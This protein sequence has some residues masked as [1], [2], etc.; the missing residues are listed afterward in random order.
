MP[1][2]FLS[3][4]AP[5]ASRKRAGHE[6]VAEFYSICQ[7]TAPPSWKPS[8]PQSRAAPRTEL[9]RL[10]SAGSTSGAV[11]P[12]TNTTLPPK[13]LRMRWAT[14]NRLEAQY[15]DLENRWAFIIH[16]RCR[17]AALSN[18]KRPTSKQTA[19]RSLADYPRGR[20][21]SFSHFKGI[22]SLHRTPSGANTRST[23][24]PSS[25]GMRFLMT[26]VP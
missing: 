9:A 21:A 5:R 2:I 4:S 6:L 13:P 15:D 23:T 1:L 3:A 17:S 12:S 25:Y 8:L 26:L 7:M 20:L 10:S 24:P 18:R 14:Y 11:P 19:F 22:S 16:A